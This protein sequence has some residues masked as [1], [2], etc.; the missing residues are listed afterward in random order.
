MPTL[1]DLTCS[2]EIGKYDQKLTEFQLQYEDA[3]A[4]CHI[5][6]PEE[7]TTFSIHLTSQGFIAESILAMIWIDGVYQCNKLHTNLRPPTPEDPRGKQLNLRMRQMIR[8]T[9]EDGVFTGSQWVFDRV[10]IG[11]S[12]QPR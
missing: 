11:N 12:Q 7:P 10:Q 8:P 2:V 4:V 5:V 3:F 6:V 9:G 1:K